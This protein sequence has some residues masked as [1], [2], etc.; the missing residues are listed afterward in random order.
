MLNTFETD[1]RWGT[2]NVIAVKMPADY[3][4]N[5]SRYVMSNTGNQCGPAG[6]GI[7]DMING[8]GPAFTAYGYDYGDYFDPN[9]SVCIGNLI[10]TGSPNI[11]SISTG[12]NNNCLLIITIAERHQTSRL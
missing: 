6:A 8:V 5:L 7:K 9:F 10:V 1:D 12:I 3:I 11:H 2:V 4:S